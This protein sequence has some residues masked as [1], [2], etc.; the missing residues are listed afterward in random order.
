MVSGD[1]AAPRAS[2]RAVLLAAGEGSRYRSSGGEG[3]KLLADFR[4]RPMLDW[5]MESALRAEI[6]PVTVVFGAATA[7]VPEGVEVVDNPD[8]AAG[9]ATSLE[10]ALRVAR[11][12]GETAVVV[13]LADQPLIEP[14]A[15]RRVARAVTD[16]ADRRQGCIAVATYDG[17]RGHP[18][19]LGQDVWP[20]L[21]RTGD[22]A[23]RTLIRAHPE[24]VLEVP[25]P[26]CSVDVD[27]VED[28]SRWS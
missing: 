13:G 17:I 3:H 1:P 23:A 24:L 21:P 8:W 9:I 2:V 14:D 28:L 5:A 27:T 4:G 16:A 12:A 20:L 15:W 10:A 22:R 7:P 19:G 6:G 26:G 11:A 25:C 18:V